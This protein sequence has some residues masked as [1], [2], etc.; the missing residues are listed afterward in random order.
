MVIYKRKIINVYMDNKLLF[1]ILIK[2]ILSSQIYSI[3]IYIYFYYID[4]S[5]ARV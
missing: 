3:Y 4:D 2:N 1:T 5:C